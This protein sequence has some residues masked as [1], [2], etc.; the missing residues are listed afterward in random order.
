MNSIQNKLKEIKDKIKKKKKIIVQQN[1]QPQP[2]PQLPQCWPTIE[3]TYVNLS[4]GTAKDKID[5]IVQQIEQYHINMIPTPKDSQIVRS[6][7]V[8]ELG[9]EGINYWLRI[10]SLKEDYNEQI[11]MGYYIYLTSIRDKISINLGAIINRYRA[12]ID[13]YNNGLNQ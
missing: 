13:K 8:A 11:Q 4:E 1:E 9:D 2:L 7:L 10:R 3:L 12:A 6:A 5:R